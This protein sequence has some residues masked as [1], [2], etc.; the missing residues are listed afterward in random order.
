MINQLCYLGGPTW[1]AKWEQMKHCRATCQWQCY[2]SPWSKCDNGSPPSEKVCWLGKKGQP[3]GRSILSKVFKSGLRHHRHHHHHHHHHHHQQ[4]HQH[5]PRPWSSVANWEYWD[6]HSIQPMIQ[7][8]TWVRQRKAPT[9]PTWIQTWKIIWGFPK[10]Q[11][12]IAGSKWW[13]VHGK[14]EHKKWMISGVSPFLETSMLHSA[15]DS[16][17]IPYLECGARQNHKMGSMEIERE[18]NQLGRTPTG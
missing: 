10:S 14:S 16:H 8:E 7:M 3:S 11:I 12:P 2:S 5:H 1:N 13:V 15:C 4:H 9:A 18:S 6:W 17:P